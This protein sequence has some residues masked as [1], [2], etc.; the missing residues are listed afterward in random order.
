MYDSGKTRNP[1]PLHY[2]CVCTCPLAFAFK[3]RRTL[4]RE[5]QNW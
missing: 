5:K 2:Y 4:K 3:V 1:F